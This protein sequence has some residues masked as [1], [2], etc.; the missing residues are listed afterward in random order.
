[1]S[2]F[3]LVLCFIVKDESKTV[4]HLFITLS[5]YGFKTLIAITTSSVVLLEASLICY[6]IVL[7]ALPVDGTLDSDVL[8]DSTNLI[9]RDNSFGLLLHCLSADSPGHH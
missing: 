9:E 6:S 7:I 5:K 4:L 8:C 3:Y 2:L 1:M